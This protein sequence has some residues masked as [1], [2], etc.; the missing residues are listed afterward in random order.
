MATT[1]FQQIYALSDAI[2]QR[3]QPQRIILFGSYADGAPTSDSDV[4]LLV[5]MPTNL[6]PAYQ[7][8]EILNHVN[9]AFAIDLLVRTPEEVQQRLAWNDS[10]MQNIVEKGR[11][12]YAAAGDRMD[13]Q[14]RG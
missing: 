10:F 5:I 4:D 8:A 14:S 6:L 1:S 13:Y 2:V 11:M 9:P 12:L 7:A 3:F